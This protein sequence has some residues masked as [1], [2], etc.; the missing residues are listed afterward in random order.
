[1]KEF[2][3]TTPYGGREICTMSTNR[4]ENNN[5]LAI[6]LW[7]E[8][9][10]FATMTVNLRGTRQYPEN[11]AFVDVNNCPWAPALIKKLGIGKPTNKYGISGFCSYPLYEFDMRKIAEYTGREF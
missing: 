2:T 7:C 1:M 11:F 5:H 9:G 8:D 3:V 6:Q 4:Y 10:P